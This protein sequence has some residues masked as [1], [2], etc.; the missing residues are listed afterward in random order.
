[1]KL[2]Q[3][4][5]LM[6]QIAPLRLAESWD[7]V[8]LLL[9]DPASEVHKVMTCLTLSPDVA[10]EAVT[11]NAE[12]VIAHHPILFRPT[13][14]IR[15]DQAGSDIVWK[16]AR[17]GIAVI[18]HH[19][20]W[21]GAMDGANAYI[22]NALE[23][24]GTGPIRPAAGPDCV[25]FVVFVSDDNLESVRNAAF[26]AGAGQIGN[27]RECSF[28]TPG[29]GTFYGQEGANP[30]VGQVGSRENA[31][32]HRLEI[33]CYKAI[34][35]RVLDAIKQAHSYEEP[36]IDIYPLAGV[37]TQTN[38]GV[39]RIGNLSKPLT[40]EE[41]AKAAAIGL[42]SS[43]TQFGRLL[44]PETG[45]KVERV[46]IACGAGDDLVDSA[47]SAGA[48]VLVTGELRFHTVL[49]A[50][51]S[52]LAT[53]IL[54]HYASERRSMEFMADLIQQKC[55]DLKVWASRLESDPIENV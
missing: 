33:I 31:A 53:V 41:L 35:R 40:V 54:G 16:L 14:V 26:N 34:Q 6:D 10:D 51:E 29:M 24:I 28:S 50:R 11:E 43:A 5:K 7:N 39:G 45:K 2:Q 38:D 30:T 42:R 20:A 13:K 1:M 12:L 8:G 55:P 17:K 44:N 37:A 18:S 23:L 46:A 27:Y 36:A 25:K 9:G 48:E 49:K 22:A 32:E 15:A 47:I 52:G 21:D 19:T 3:I 4:M